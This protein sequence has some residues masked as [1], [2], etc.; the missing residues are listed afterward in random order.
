MFKVATKPGIGMLK[1]RRVDRSQTSVSRPSCPLK[2]YE[3]Y[4][5]PPHLQNL[6]HQPI[7][8]RTRGFSLSAST[9]EPG[10][11]CP[12]VRDEPMLEFCN[13]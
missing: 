2:T 9:S 11:L 13:L 4:L 6:F 1:G 7:P 10:W 5:A 12:P 3:L 8:D